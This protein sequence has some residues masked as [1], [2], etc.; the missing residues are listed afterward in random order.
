MRTARTFVWVTV[1]LAWWA[2]AFG[3]DPSLDISQYAHTSWKV[4]DGFAKGAITSLAQTADGYLW[5]GTEFGLLRFDGV[6]AVAWQPPA[7]QQLPGS[8]ITAL[9]AA[10][11][12]TLWI[13]T[14]TGLA[15]WKDRRLRQAPELS[16]QAVTSLLEARDGTVWVGT[17]A[18]SGGTLCHIQSVVVY[19]EA[20]NGTLGPGVKSL[21]EDSKGTLWVGLA[22]GLWRWKPGA[23]EFFAIRD[24]LFGVTSFAEDEKGQLLFGSHAGIHR[25]VNGRV[26]P[27]PLSGAANRLPVTQLFADHD[28]GL[29]IGTSEHGLMHIHQQGK[30]DVFSQPDGLSGDYVKR[31]L[32][33]REGNIWV[34]TLDGVDRFRAYAIPTIS[35]RQGLSNTVA[36]SVLASK[37]GSVWISTIS[38][39]DHWNNGRISPF[40]SRGGTRKSDGKLNGEPPDGGLLQDSSG[41]IWTPTADT[42]GYLQDEHYLSI[43]HVPNPVPRAMAEGPVGHLWV[44]TMRAGLFH[45]FQEHVIEQIPWAGLGR[46]GFAKV[47]AADPSQRGVWLG[48]SEG[49]VA[50]FANGAIRASYSAANGLGEG[51]VN[52]LRFESRGALWVGSDTGLS[53]IKDGQVTTLTSKNGLPCDQVLAFIQDDERSMWLY[54]ACGLVRI[55]EAELDAWVA[56]PSR[57]VK[58]KLFDTSDGVRGHAV[59]NGYPPTMTKATDGKIWFVP[60]DGVSVIDPHHLAFNKLPPPVHV[61][62]IIADGKTYDASSHRSGGLRLPPRVRDLTIRYTALS[63]VVPEKVRFRFKLEGQDPDWRKVVNERDVQYSNLGPDNYRFRVLA[64]NNSGVWNE[65]GATLDFA[66]AP[67]YY[68]TNWFRALCVLTFLAMLWMVYEL[69]VRHLARQFNMTLEARVNERT[70]IARDLHDTLLQS[71][72][73][74]LLGFQAVSNLLPERP[75]EA[76]ERLDS[77]IDQAAGAITEGRDAIQQLRS[78]TV[79]TNDLA[80]AVNTLGEELAAGDT[81]PNAAVFQVQVEGTQRNLHPIL[82]DEVYRIAGE[83]LRN[84]FRHAQAHQIEVEIRYDERQLRLRVRDDGKGID[85]KVLSGDGREG[86]Y[87][88]HG[89][90]ERAKLVGGKLAVWSALDSGTEIELSIPASA[91]YATSPTRRRSWLSEKVSGKGTAAKS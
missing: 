71:F 7:G 91:A 12:G 83:A 20:A 42:F 80:V 88:L 85:P 28:G 33:D 44:T 41:R 31:F 4:R 64:C 86:H 2:C 10:R 36:L 55:T 47:L 68:Q 34:A 75:A 11:D 60:V 61:E 48:F 21:Y 82:R 1:V 63:L 59:T 77:A 25:L 73:G 29:W 6:R 65:Q 84:A 30:T 53:R 3:L 58:T 9:L 45:L 50:Y 14:T 72:H 70:R 79:V 56:N 39:L 76:K 16:G 81:N 43:L 35:T 89:M 90:R 27:Y 57:L 17:Y 22:N 18:Q 15:S 13:G 49:G 23:A 87:G 54:M 52:D 5:A 19:C 40:G 67:V 74:L 62:E 46:K 32:E 24:D 26:D 69:R 8:F 51:P 37:D 66:I 78:S 38:A